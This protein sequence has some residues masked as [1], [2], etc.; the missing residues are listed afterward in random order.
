MNRELE[1]K[2]LFWSMVSDYVFACAY[3]PSNVD[4]HRGK[5]AGFNS[6]IYHIGVSED[7]FSLVY[8]TT[9]AV[10]VTHTQGDEKLA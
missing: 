2:K 3:T 4:Y 9:F 8:S 10:V 5:I 6:T 1:L 7:F